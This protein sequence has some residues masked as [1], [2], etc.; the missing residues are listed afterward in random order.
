M[1]DSR[2]VADRSRDSLVARQDEIRLADLVQIFSTRAPLMGVVIG[3]SLAS[4]MAFLW[5]AKPLYRVELFVLPPLVED[6]TLRDNRGVAISNM[7]LA[8]L[9]F[10]NYTPKEVYGEF[11]VNLDS[12]RLRREYYDREDIYKQYLLLFGAPDWS[13]QRVFEDL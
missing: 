12:R 11:Q 10:E 13:T 1:N 7:E 9:P 5:W 2:D 8:R 4:A 3:L 6:V